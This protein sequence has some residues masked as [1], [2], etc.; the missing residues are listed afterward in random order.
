MSEV[1]QVPQLRFPEFSGNWESKIF[2]DV[3]ERITTKNKENN[4]NVLTISAQQGLINQKDYFNKSV[5]AKDVTG[6]YLLHKDDFAYNKS[7]SQGYPL[8]AIKR[9]KKYDKGV[10]ST[11]YICFKSIQDNIDFLEQV[12]NGGRLN[13]EIHKI[14][15]EGAR[16][17]GLLNISVVEFFKDIKLNIPTK[18]EQQKIAAFLTAVDNKIEQLSKKQALL[19]EYKKA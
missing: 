16:N 8:G 12:F 10:V 19:G 7:Y 2:R 5:S 13:H 9:L 3:F 14:A 6:Y 11:L 17:H 4:E 1:A 18:P 15:Q